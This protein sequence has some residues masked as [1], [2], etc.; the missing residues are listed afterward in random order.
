MM[1]V[2]R[3]GFPGGPVVK[4]SPCSV[5][6]MGLIP[7]LGRSHMPQSNESLAPHLLS[8]YSRAGK[9]HLLACMARARALQ[10]EKQL[11]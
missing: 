10:Q 6:N 7:G 5:G 3:G 1:K 9:L 8:P 2:N 4:N 11:Q